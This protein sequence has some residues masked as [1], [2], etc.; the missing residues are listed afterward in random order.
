MKPVNSTVDRSGHYFQL[1]TGSNDDRD[2]DADID[3]YDHVDVDNDDDA[4]DGDVDEANNFNNNNNYNNNSN[5]NSNNEYNQKLI[6]GGKLVSCSVFR[7]AFWFQPL[8]AHSAFG[9]LIGQLSFLLVP[10]MV[11]SKMNN[12][13]HRTKQ[14]YESYTFQPLMSFW[15]NTLVVNKYPISSTLFPN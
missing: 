14:T 10:N 15:C 13:E 12:H 8:K 9:S 11:L 3:D 5:S 1:I 7:Q 2:N 6:R 4:S